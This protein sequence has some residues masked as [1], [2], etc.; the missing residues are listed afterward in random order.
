MIRLWTNFVCLFTSLVILNVLSQISHVKV[1]CTLNPCTFSEWNPKSCAEWRI[2]SQIS[3]LCFDVWTLTVWLLK[4]CFSWN[5][6]SQSWHLKDRSFEL[7]R[8]LCWFRWAFELNII[9]YISHLWSIVAECVKFSDIT[10]MCQPSLA[11][12]T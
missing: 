8:F 3:H 2:F 6:F 1:F 5:H 12:P 10:I 9:S 4:P 11:A 7:W